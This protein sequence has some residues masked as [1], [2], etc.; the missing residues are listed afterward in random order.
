MMNNDIEFKLIKP[1]K[2]LADFVDS[3]WMLCNLSSND[4]EIV[5]LPD[6]RMDFTLSQSTMEPFEIVCSGLETQPQPIIFKA[7]TRIFAISF[8][9]LAV[10][11]ILDR[12]ISNILNYA[13]HLPSHF[14]EFE[15]DDLKDFEH[16]CHKASLKI[17]SLLPRKIDLRRQ[18]L[19]EL[20]YQSQGEI[21]IK[22]I[23]R[24][25]HW[26]SRQINRYFKDQFGLSLKTYC[27]IVRFRASFEQ[28]K[29]GHLYPKQQFA[30]QS[31]FIKE[32]KKFSG[33]SP[34]QLKRNQ[35]GRFIQFS[36]DVSR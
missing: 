14:W 11:Y 24:Q 20:I 19:F 15:Q 33:V 32:V 8:K 2:L 1:D 17:Q 21:T 30:D 28:I 35:N 13:E 22:E 9:L 3:F 31:H 6:G 36:V 27:N 26:G 12:S 16:F 18:K 29:D 34:K 25:V 5:V 7:N 10:E 4:R 23:S